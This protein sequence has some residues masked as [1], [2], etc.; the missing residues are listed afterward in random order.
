MTK[1]HLIKNRSRTMQWR[2]VMLA[3]A[4]AAAVWGTSRE[5]F[6]G[7]SGLTN[8]ICGVPRAA[9]LPVFLA[10][11]DKPPV[12]PNSTLEAFRTTSAEEHA[13]AALFMAQIGAGGGSPSAVG[14]AKAQA[15]IEREIAAQAAK[16]KAREARKRDKAPPKRL[17]EADETRARP[18][19]PAPAVCR[20][21][22]SASIVSAEAIRTALKQP[23]DVSFVEVPI[24]DV[25]ERLQETLKIPIQLDLKALADAGVAADT[26]VTRN[27][28][29]ISARKTLEL[30]LRELDLTWVIRNNVLLI[31]T[32]E[33]ADHILENKVYD[34][35]DL[36]GAVN[37]EG[38]PVNDFDS[39]VDAITCTIKPA[40]WDNGGGP[41]CASPFENDRMAVLVVNQTERVH[42]ELEALLADLRKADR[43][44]PA[45][46]TPRRVLYRAQIV[47]PKASPV[48]VSPGPIAPSGVPVTAATALKAGDAV[49]VEW[50]NQWWAGNVVALVPDGNVKIHYA[51]WDA[52]WD[53]V[54][55]RSRLRSPADKR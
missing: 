38:H 5:L 30:I 29:G 35:G 36:V 52:R 12:A 24:S 28:R 31:T 13:P 50:G 51:G 14:G 42:E 2:W 49:Q 54:V 3:A 45:G 44:A 4:A 25:M 15:A 17:A 16:R 39:L 34:V 9:C 6:H 46:G 8:Y 27:L 1:P 21:A 33:Q 7:A 23:I 48:Q 11:A 32:P 26:P 55:P 41:G 40:S 10:L 19:Q 22:P 43:A 20:I 18:A 47:R 53:E 37:E